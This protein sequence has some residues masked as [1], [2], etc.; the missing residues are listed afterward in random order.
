MPLGAPAA[1]LMGVL[2]AWEGPGINAQNRNLLR[3]Q[4]SV[5]GLYRLVVADSVYGCPSLSAQVSVVE[6]SYTP[7]VALADEDT[8][9]CVTPQIFLNGAGSASGP[10]FRYI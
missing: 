7:A 9:D 10:V 2:A 4:V 5:P 1:S 3:P 6:A 8:L